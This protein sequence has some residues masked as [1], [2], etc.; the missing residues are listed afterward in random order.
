MNNYGIILSEQSQEWT[1]PAFEQHAQKDVEA[2]RDGMLLPMREMNQQDFGVSG[3][4]ILQAVATAY[5][6]GNAHST[7]SLVWMECLHMLRRE[8]G[9]MGLEEIKHA[10]RLAAAGK[11]DVNIVA[12][13]GVFTVDILGKVMA[14]YKE[15]TFMIRADIL[16]KKAEMQ[17]AEKQ[18]AINEQRKED[19]ED[20]VLE[21]FALKTENEKIQK[22]QDV[23]VGWFKIM[24]DREFLTATL[25][26][27]KQSWKEAKLTAVG[28]FKQDPDGVFK[29]QNDIRDTRMSLHENPEM[30][31]EKLQGRAEVIY[32]K[33]LCLL[34][35]AP[36]NQK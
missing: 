10:F 1:L 20:L 21:I 14:A 6:G 5:C 2:V 3:T 31:P 33:I 13:A 23:G 18:D 17:E 9:G 19:F 30:F 22:W 4:A 24:N 16:R 11:T 32:G 28:E 27:K 25:G 7:T 34:S 26:E 15:Y 35:F 29:N 12:Y 36:F 8:F